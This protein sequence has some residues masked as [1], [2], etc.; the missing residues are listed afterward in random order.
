MIYQ[1]ASEKILVPACGQTVE[2]A[3]VATVPQRLRLLGNAAL[4]VTCTGL[5]LWGAKALE[6]PSDALAVASPP[7]VT[8]TLGA[9]ILAPPVTAAPPADPAT[10]SS[11]KVGTATDSYEYDGLKRH[12]VCK[13]IANEGE[14]E[15]RFDY[16]GDSPQA[17]HIMQAE[18]AGCL[19]QGIGPIITLPLNLTPQQAT[20]IATQLQ[21]QG[22]DQFVIGN[23]VNSPLFSDLTPQQYVDYLAQIGMAI[24]TVQPDAKIWGFALA[25]G[26]DSVAY[27]TTGSRYADQKYGSLAKLMYGLDVH[28]Y[29]GV[30]KALQM[31]A[32]YQ[33]IV[34]LP[35]RIGEAGFI[36]RDPAHPNGIS[37]SEQA[38]SELSLYTAVANLNVEELDW[39]RDVAQPIDPFDTAN[40]SANGIFRPA[41]YVMRSALTGR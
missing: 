38:K 20:E 19:A 26:Y 35:T 17:M 28:S 25:A 4:A 10:T 12:S 14:Q 37:P 40:I 6:A 31:L 11:V 21:L 16:L 13:D 9:N 36:L 7:G 2:L 8:Q 15:I 23:E 24:R 33:A 41:Y 22:V 34:P 29:W 39:F 5:A 18:I 30:A 27:L 1:E 32:T 3:D